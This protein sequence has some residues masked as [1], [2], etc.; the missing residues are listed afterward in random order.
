VQ[1]RVADGSLKSSKSGLIP[2][3]KEALAWGGAAPG[4]GDYE[5]CG[6]CR[7]L[8]ELHWRPILSQR[9]LAV[10]SRVRRPI[11]AGAESNPD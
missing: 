4:Q 10:R 6:S 8:P 1:K 2:G 9:L 7:R 5:C 11:I 3:Q